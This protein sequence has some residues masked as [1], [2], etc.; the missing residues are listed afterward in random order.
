MADVKNSSSPQA[1]HLAG[2]RSQ[3]SQVLV[4]STA[5]HCGAQRTQ[6]AHQAGWLRS[7]AND[8]QAGPQADN[9]CRADIQTCS[10]AVRLQAST[11][12]AHTHLG[13]LCLCCQAVVALALCASEDVAIAGEAT[14]VK[15]LQ[16]GQQQEVCGVGVGVGGWV[17]G[18]VVVVGGELCPGETC[19]P[20]RRVLVVRALQHST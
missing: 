19:D 14:L 4:A 8:V 1:L 20:P 13:A 3:A 11:H 7:Q 17:G 12:D 2:L 9:K 18:W 5:L 16:E 6:Q 15:A 10:S